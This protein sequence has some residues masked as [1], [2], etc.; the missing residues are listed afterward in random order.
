MSR[1]T[2]PLRGC[3]IILP[4]T[5]FIGGDDHLI[6]R[7]D[8]DPKYQRS[9]GVVI[10]APAGL[11]LFNSRMRTLDKAVLITLV[12]KLQWS[13]IDYGETRSGKTWTLR[14]AKDGEHVVASVRESGIATTGLSFQSIANAIHDGSDWLIEVLAEANMAIT[15]NPIDRDRAAR[16]LNAS[17]KSIYSVNQVERSISNLKALGVIIGDERAGPD[18]LY[19]LLNPFFYCNGP[20]HMRNALIRVVTNSDTSGIVNFSVDLTNAGHPRRRTL[21]ADLIRELGLMKDFINDVLE[22]QALPEEMRER[23]NQLL[24]D[25]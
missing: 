12:S 15:G 25:S 8:N 18:N 9:F 5:T 13:K 22:I 21:N 2:R 11:A 16:I 6:V 17:K 14:Y 7:H 4:P 23:G 19:Y 20:I 1:P 24:G 10:M 3:E